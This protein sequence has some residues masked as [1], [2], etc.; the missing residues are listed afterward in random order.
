MAAATGLSFAAA[1]WGYGDAVSGILGS[2]VAKAGYLSN[3][4]A[5]PIHTVLDSAKDGRRHDSERTPVG[6]TA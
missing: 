6:G 4:G 2:S 1:A 5:R 3:A